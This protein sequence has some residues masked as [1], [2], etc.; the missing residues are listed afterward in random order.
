[1]TKPCTWP[2]CG[3]PDGTF[4]MDCE[5]VAHLYKTPVNEERREAMDT[6]D[7]FLALTTL[8]FN[9]AASAV[10]ILHFYEKDDVTGLTMSA[11]AAGFGVAACV[12]LSKFCETGRDSFLFASK[13]AIGAYVPLSAVLLAKMVL[14]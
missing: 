5:R 7:R 14:Q 2:R 12:L 9:M 8:A 6:T 13:L 11:V 1:M 4:D 3:C 10:F